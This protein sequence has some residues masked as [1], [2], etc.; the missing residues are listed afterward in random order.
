[1]FFW[2]LLGFLLVVLLFIVVASI[3]DDQKKGVDASETTNFH[4][5]LAIIGSIVAIGLTF[6]ITMIVGMSV[7]SEKRVFSKG[8]AN[9]VTLLTKNDAVV[10]ASSSI[11]PHWITHPVAFFTGKK[12]GTEYYSWYEKTANGGIQPRTIE[13]NSESKIKIFEISAHAHPKVIRHQFET[14]HG[15]TSWVGP[16]D[17]GDENEVGSTVW[18]LY[19][20]KGSVLIRNR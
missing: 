20:P 8:E 1:M 5:G 13:V 6:F 2:C 3:Y 16:M 12:N 9:K 14:V 17:L 7:G 11:S 15:W 4:I 18:D 10:A 19:I